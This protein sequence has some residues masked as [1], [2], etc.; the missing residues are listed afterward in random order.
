ML[1]RT[2]QRQSSHHLTNHDDD[3]AVVAVQHDPS[4]SP[5]IRWSKTKCKQRATVAAAKCRE[6]CLRC[7]CGLFPFLV[8]RTVLIYINNNIHRSIKACFHLAAILHH[9]IYKEACNGQFSSPDSA[10]G[11]K[12]DWHCD[13]KYNHLITQFLFQLSNITHLTLK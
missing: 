9:Y 4:S 2:L 1:A 10:F 12:G 8:L 5:A 7:M 3:A 6:N 13:L 11:I